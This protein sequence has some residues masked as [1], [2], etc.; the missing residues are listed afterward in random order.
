[1]QSGD[2]YGKK[3]YIERIFLRAVHKP[4]RICEEREARGYDS[5]G[6]GTGSYRKST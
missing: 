1:M 5:L 4:W 6:G 2:F 3:T